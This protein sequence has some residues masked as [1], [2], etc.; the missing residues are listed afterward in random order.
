MTRRNKRV[1]D[2]NQYAIV[3]ADDVDTMLV[4]TELEGTDD[5]TIEIVSTSGATSMILNSEAMS[6]ITARTL[7]SQRH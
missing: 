4:I 6:F 2:N 1:N 5:V 3:H 7:K